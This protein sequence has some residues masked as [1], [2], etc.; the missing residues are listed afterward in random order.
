VY[1]IIEIIDTVE[2][3]CYHG[4]TVYIS[5]Y[6]LML[7]LILFFC[8]FITQSVGDHISKEAVLLNQTFSITQF[9]ESISRYN[10]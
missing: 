3:A 9:T 6:I 1:F 7:I 5:V 2:L 4:A 10:S 8:S